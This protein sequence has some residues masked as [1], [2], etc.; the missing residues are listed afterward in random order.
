M[1]HADLLC[2]DGSRATIE[3]S[4]AFSILI[5]AQRAGAALRHD[6]GGKALCGTCRVR[7]ISGTLSPV[8]ERERLRLDAVGA[9]PGVRL[10]CQARPGSNL[11][12]EAVLPLSGPTHP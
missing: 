4:P 3:V 10:A 8:L 1:P 11:S 5:A 12:L 6:C 7:V 9:G 2:A